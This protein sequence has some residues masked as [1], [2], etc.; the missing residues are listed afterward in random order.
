MNANLQRLGADLTWL[1]TNH[2]PGKGG[3]CI[4]IAVKYSQLVTNVSCSPRGCWTSISLDSPFGFTLIS[5]YA[6]NSVLVDR[7]SVWEELATFPNPCITGHDFNIVT[8]SDVTDGSKRGWLYMELKR[9]C[10]IK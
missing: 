9:K 2:T 6:P 3:A 10:G 5:L 1:S 8:N 7:A 4:G